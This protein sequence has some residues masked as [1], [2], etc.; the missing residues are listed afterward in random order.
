MG[1]TKPMNTTPEFHLLELY[2]RVAEAP[3]AIDRLR[4][5]VLDLAV[6][7][8]LVEQ[9]PEDEPVEDLL[10]RIAAEKTRLVKA[11]KIRNSKVQ[12][13]NAADLPYSI[14]VNWAW[15]TL[16]AVGDW[17]AG[18]TPSRS[19]S[20]L[21]GG[22]ITWLKSGELGDRT[23]L[24]TSEETV[25]EKAVRTGSFRR[26]KPGDIL[27]AM[28]GATIGKLAI[29]A[30]EAV[31]NQ[32]VCGCT[33][34][35]GVYNHYLFL[36][37]LAQRSAFQTSSEGGAQPNISKVKIVGTAFPLPPLP[38]QHRIV[39]KVDELMALLDRLETTRTQRETTRDRLTTASLTRLTAPETSET[40]FP[41][42]ARFAL[43]NLNRLTSRPDQVK[44]LRQTIL[45]LAVQGKLVEQDPEDEPAEEL[46][47]RVAAERTS[48]VEAGEIKKPK[49]VS[50]IS[51]EEKPFDLPTGWVWC[52]LGSLVL[53]SDAGWSPRTENHRREGDTWGVLKVSAVSW[54]YFDPAAN[55]QVLPGTEPRPQAQVHKG[56]FLI[57]RA[58]TA[59]LVARAIIIPDEPRNLM[60]SDKIVRLRLGTHINPHFA[61]LVN[62]NADYSRTYYAASAT[63][64]SPSMKNVSRE[65]ILNL[66]IPLPPLVEQ[67]RIT[68]QVGSLMSI[69]DRLENA[70]E[71]ADTTRAVLFETQIYDT[72]QNNK[73]NQEA[74]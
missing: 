6:R 45:N 32:A 53:S 71:Q 66:L 3:D 62:N 25:T 10:E 65:M 63:G 18:S 44:V 69:C 50:A 2:D 38:E 16:G 55:K 72:L 40:D 51:D 24:K 58:N 28:Y 54:D 43:D 29:L 39:A 60:M 41:A 67:N 70:L 74:A 61:L 73:Q 31:T 9:D 26:N 47:K 22:D 37:L 21:Y 12:S 57:S 8:T 7:G 27:I 33:P 56:D 15:T 35:N 52:R 48:L 68:A 59:E 20:D 1:A 11:G 49:P 23:D 30:E 4:K 13:V 14:P 46:L 34:F 17:G 64:V 42:H 19:N 5:F 36:F